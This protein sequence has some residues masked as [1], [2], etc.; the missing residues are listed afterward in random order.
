MKPSGDNDVA[1][2]EFDDGIRAFAFL[3]WTRKSSV[4]RF[5]GAGG[6][7]TGCFPSF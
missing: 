5:S 1:A 3:L 6:S 7:L 4:S 2:Q